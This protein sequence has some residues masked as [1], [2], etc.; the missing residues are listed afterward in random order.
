[1]KKFMDTREKINE[2]FA[3]DPHHSNLATTRIQQ[4]KLHL[5]LQSKADR[6][7]LENMSMKKVNRSDLNVVFGKISLLQHEIDQVI[8]LFNESLK[9]NLN[10]GGKAKNRSLEIMS[11][12]NALS[13]QTKKKC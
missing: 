9:M 7:E 6:Y 1:M 2:A 8:M 5:D 13:S 10:Q 3:K 4:T 12:L 11:Q